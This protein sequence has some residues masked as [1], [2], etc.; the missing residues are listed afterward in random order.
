M[1]PLSQAVFREA[2]DKILDLTHLDLSLF[3]VLELQWFIRMLLL[4]SSVSCSCSSTLINTL[5]NMSLLS[6]GL[7]GGPQV[8]TAVVWCAS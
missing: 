8:D 3:E 7:S 1:E 6:D 5:S 4:P 2:V